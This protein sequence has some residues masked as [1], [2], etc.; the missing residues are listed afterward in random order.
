MSYYLNKNMYQ[1]YAITKEPPYHFTQS[2]VGV[3]LGDKAAF[4]QGIWKIFSFTF[5]DG[6]EFEGEDITVEKVAQEKGFDK[7]NLVLLATCGMDVYEIDDKDTNIC[8]ANINS[9]KS[10]YDAIVDKDDRDLTWQQFIEFVNEKNNTSYN[11]ESVEDFFNS[12]Q[13]RYCNADEFAE[14][15]VN[16]IDNIPFYISNHIDW[17]GVAEDLKESFFYLEDGNY[18]YVF[19]Y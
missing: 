17:K 18:T 12:F 3:L 8:I 1:K 14:E 7:E 9:A 6:D 15:Y 5:G 13:G 10:A 19:R 2:S 16:E 11:T 4:E